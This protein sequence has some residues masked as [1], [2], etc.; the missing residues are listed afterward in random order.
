[1]SN[2][3]SKKAKE[4]IENYPKNG[5]NNIDSRIDNTFSSLKF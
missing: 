2:T 1:M 4:H 5:Q 3:T